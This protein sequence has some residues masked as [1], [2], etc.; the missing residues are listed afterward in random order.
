MNKIFKFKYNKNASDVVKLPGSEINKHSQE[1]NKFIPFIGNAS[2]IRKSNTNLPELNLNPQPISKKSVIL[3]PSIILKDSELKEKFGNSLNF[4]VKNKHTRK[5]NNDLEEDEFVKTNTQS[6]QKNNETEI[7]KLDNKAKQTLRYSMIYQTFDF[8]KSGNK[9]KI[10]PF[11]SNYINTSSSYA[12]ESQQ[13]TS[14]SRRKRFFNF[15]N[16]DVL[17]K[18][19]TEFKKMS[20]IGQE[21]ILLRELELDPPR[22]IATKNAKPQKK[23]N[24]VFFNKAKAIHMNF[25]ETSVIWPKIKPDILNNA[26]DLEY[27]FKNIIKK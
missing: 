9:K 6:S 26:I 25:K 10:I 7:K 4:I 3:D 23:I 27:I 14:Q 19:L 11:P 12:S 5:K 18:Q 13:I 22:I 24:F 15:K 17:Q 20:K 16:M 8:M 21:E 1:S 2:L